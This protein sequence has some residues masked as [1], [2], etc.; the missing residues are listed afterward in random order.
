MPKGSVSYNNATLFAENRH[1]ENNSNIVCDELNQI[2]FRIPQDYEWQIASRCKYN[3]ETNL[4]DEYLDY[5]ISIVGDNAI[6]SCN[7]INYQGCCDCIQGVDQ[8]PESI[9]P[10]GLYGTSGNLREWVVNNNS[11]MNTNKLI[12]GSFLSTFDEITTKSVFYFPSNSAEHHSF[13]FRTVFDAD[14]FL[15]IWRVCAE[16]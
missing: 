12:G 1:P 9:T 16:R 14:E 8:Y 13:G 4:C 6:P 11:S 2:Q 15:E 7:V 10:F 5:P 3:W